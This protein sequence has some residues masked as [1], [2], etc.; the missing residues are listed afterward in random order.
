MSSPKSPPKSRQTAWMWLLLF[1]V[2]SYSSR[3]VG[4]CEVNLLHARLFDLRQVS[5]RQLR[6]D[7]SDVLA[8]QRHQRPALGR[9]HLPGGEAGRRE[10]FHFVFGL[11]ENL[12]RGF[13][14]EHG[15]FPLAI[16]EGLHEQTGRILLA[17]QRAQALARSLAHLGGIAAEKGGRGGKELAFDEG[18]AGRKLKRNRARGRAGSGGLLPPILR[19]SVRDS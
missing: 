12:R 13:R 14:V 3:N 11:G 1:C 6:P 19:E 8:H 9:G 5:V 16:I 10:R 18:E 17:G 2:L 7:A 4:P 15:H